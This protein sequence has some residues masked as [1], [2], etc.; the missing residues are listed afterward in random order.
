MSLTVYLKGLA[1]YIPGIYPEL[2]SVIRPPRTGGTDCARYCYSVWLRHLVMASL[3]GLP[4]EPNSV[5]ELGPG[6]SLG[7]GIAALLSGA[8]AYYAFDVVPYATN[9]RNLK[10]IEELVELFRS[11]APIPADSEFPLVRPRLVSYEFP[12]Q[13]LS[14][15]RLSR[16]LSIRRVNTIRDAVQN[17]SPRR[18]NGIQIAYRVPWD[19]AD[20][21]K[22]HSIDLV[23]SQAVLEHVDDLERTY[24]A[25]FQWLKPSD[26]M[27]HTIDFRSHGTAAEW[28]G[29]WSYSELQWKVIHGRRT[30]L[31]NRH[32]HSAHLKFA[33]H[34]GFRIVSDLRDENSTGLKRMRLAPSFQGMS[35]EDLVTA[36]AFLQA[37]PEKQAHS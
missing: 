17:L 11:R 8:T 19:E 2:V 13:I 4:T 36:G 26:Y 5:A 30:W 10:I 27:S 9:E 14:Q 6:D 35:D 3:N 31:L 1:T 16:A 12:S 25:L 28:N 37:I 23:Y 15:S 33:K 18:S 29:H 32:P 24:R 21:I 22:P 7:T 34:A 20:V